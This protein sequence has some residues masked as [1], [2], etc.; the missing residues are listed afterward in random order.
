MKAKNQY[1][2]Y[3]GAVAIK[4]IGK[5]AREKIEKLTQK[6]IYLELFVSVK[7]G[8]SKNKDGLKEMGYHLD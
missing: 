3:K 5:V 4:R 6:K 7:K 2:N 1:K 8:W